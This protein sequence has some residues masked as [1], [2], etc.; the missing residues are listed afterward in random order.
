LLPKLIDPR[1]KDRVSDAVANA[2]VASGVA[3][4]DLSPKKAVSI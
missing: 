4:L 1:L 3:R 2:A